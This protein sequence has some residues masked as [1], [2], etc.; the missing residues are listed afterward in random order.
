M[1]D[2]ARAA[3][4]GRS[5]FRSSLRSEPRPGRTGPADH[6]LPSPNHLCAG[7]LFSME[8]N[9]VPFVVSNNILGRVGTP[10]LSFQFPVS[11]FQPAPS[12]FRLIWVCL[13]LLS[14]GGPAFASSSPEIRVV[15]PPELERIASQVELLAQEDFTEVLNLT[16]RIDFS[17]SITVVLMPEG[18]PLAE[19]MPRWVAGYARGDRRTVVLFPA[20]V[21]SYPDRNMRTLLRHEVAHVLVWE[22]AA[23]RAVPRWLN[24]GIAT[25]AAREWGLEDRARY[26]VAV[27]G[28]GPRSTRQLDRAFRGNAGEVRRAYALSAGFIRFL[29]TEYGILTP[30]RILDGLADGQDLDQAFL[31]ATGVELRRAERRFFKDQAMWNTWVPFLTSSAALWMAVTALALL[32][33]ARRRSRNRVM[34]DRW[35]EEEH[36]ESGSDERDC[37]QDIN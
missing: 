24:E 26:A 1:P 3:R 22:A 4:E 33:I 36:W 19:E 2:P 35:D 10:E 17:E 16:G 30:A 23:G 27:I 25:V 32:A 15:G 5:S 21:P 11:S 28:S 12:W 37:D 7:I 14:V 6:R 20:R 34:Y 8:K 18:S 13:F 29:Q 9:S 31:M